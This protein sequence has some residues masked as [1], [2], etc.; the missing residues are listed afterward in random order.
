MSKQ[1]LRAFLDWR[2]CSDPWPGGDIDVVD[3]WLDE[4][5]R[6]FGFAHWVDAYHGLSA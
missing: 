2:M 1:Q 4:M 3:E 5:S 6:V